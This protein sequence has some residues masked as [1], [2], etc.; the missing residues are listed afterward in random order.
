MKPCNIC[1]SMSDLFY[2]AY[3]LK[4]HPCNWN[5]RIAFFSSHGLIIYHGMCI[6]HLLNPFI[7]F[8][9]I[10]A[11][12]NNATVRVQISLQDPVFI[13]FEYIP[14]S[15]IA[16]SCFNILRNFSIVFYIGCANLHSHQQTIGVPFSSTT[17]VIS[18]LLV[19]LWFLKGMW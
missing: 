2:L 10:L 1:P 12:V 3:A 14:C 8:F 5:G 16:R 11:I 17:L 4:L 9:H 6:S 7:H 19:M 18:C 15:G 13:S